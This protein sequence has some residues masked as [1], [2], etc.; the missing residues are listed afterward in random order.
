MVEQQ[1][2]FY[3]YFGEYDQAN[4]CFYIK[5]ISVEL[6]NFPELDFNHLVSY[7]WFEY[8]GKIVGEY[9]LVFSLDGEIYDDYLIMH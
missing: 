7:L 1:E 3:S 6:K 5:K 2:E 9:R 4:L 8:K